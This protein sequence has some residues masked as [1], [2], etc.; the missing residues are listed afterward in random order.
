MGCSNSKI[1]T[2]E[3]KRSSRFVSRE[4]V[5]TQQE[6]FKD[7]TDLKIFSAMLVNENKEEFLDYY[8]PIETIGHG[9]FGKGK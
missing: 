3:S 5:D 7:G 8:K 9:A 6:N 4:G 1:D 2:C